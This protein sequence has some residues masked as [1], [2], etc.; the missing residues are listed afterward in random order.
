MLFTLELT[1]EDVLGISWTSDNLAEILGYPPEAAIGS[2]WW[3]T[4]IHPD[5]LAGVR[6][7]TKA[8]LFTRDQ[9][10]E[11]YRFRHGDGSYRWTRCDM[12]LIRD[13]TG[14]PSEA[15]GAWSVSRR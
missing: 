10:T 8:A 14:R 2:D 7:R 15:V 1:V 12:R 5:D 4:S 6:A 11:E 3:L 13:E 9:S